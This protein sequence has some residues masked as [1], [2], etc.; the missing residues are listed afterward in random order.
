M[1][2]RSVAL[3]IETSNGYSRGMLD[4]VISYTKEHDNWSVYL[5]KQGHSTPP[6]AWL[7]TWGGDGI[8]A[9]IETDSVGRQLKRCRV[10]IIDLS[11][12]RHN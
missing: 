7:E 6:P 3:L 1:T 9:R 10:L 8:I 5:T 12:A 2:R 11:A 4:E